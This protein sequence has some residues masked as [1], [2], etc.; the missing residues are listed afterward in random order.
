MRSS[1]ALVAADQDSALITPTSL[2]IYADIPEDKIIE[3]LK[4]LCDRRNHP[5]LIHCNKGKVRRCF[6]V[7]LGFPTDAWRAHV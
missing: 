4:V 6:P 7:A 2:S 1:Y 5:I 3:A